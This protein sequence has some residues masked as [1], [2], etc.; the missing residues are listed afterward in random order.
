MNSRAVLPGLGILTLII[1]TFTFAPSCSKNT[2]PPTH[3]TVTVIKNDTTTLTDTLY[4]TKPDPTVNLSNGLLL[5]LPF[6]GNI[7]DSSGNDNP[8]LAVGNVLTYDEH[9]YPNSAFGADGKGEKIYVTNNGSIQFDTAWAISLGFMVNDN[10]IETY[11]SMVDPTT[12]AGPSFNFGNTVAYAP[13]LACGTGDISTDCGSPGVVNDL[14]ITDSTT[15]TPVPGSWYKAIVIYHKGTVQIY[16]N[17]NLIST[18]VGSGTQALLCPNSQVV[19]GDWW[20]GN[21]PNNSMNLNGKLDNI[22]LYNRVLT[23]HE[24]ALLSSSYLITSNSQKPPL[25]HM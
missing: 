14:N 15:F 17:G 24:I 7:A 6:S 16:I 19:I 3:D 21:P 18:K 11:I 23:P 1:T 9:G 20:N 25:R 12:G 13:Y 4:G 2:S 22:R 8:T 10:R 5:Y